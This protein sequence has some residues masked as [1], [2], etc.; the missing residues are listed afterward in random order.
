MIKNKYSDIRRN[1]F[2]F[3]P[4]NS[5]SFMLFLSIFSLFFSS[6]SS[7]FACFAFAFS[8]LSSSVV[9]SF[10]CST[11]FSF[12]QPF[13]KFNH[14]YKDDI[15][16]SSRVFKI[17]YTFL[18]RFKN[19][20]LTEKLGECYFVSLI[21]VPI[22]NVL[23]VEFHICITLKSKIAYKIINELLITKLKNHVLY[24]IGKLS[25]L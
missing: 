2:F 7:L 13:Q 1:V 21:L 3:V 4:Y 16:L 6:F 25:H 5:P 20:T 23:F 22:F 11:N 17:E 10:F 9:S 18:V 12:K 14:Y 24:P 19:Y 8:L 15:N